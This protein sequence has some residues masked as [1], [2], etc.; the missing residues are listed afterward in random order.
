MTVA[1]LSGRVSG[2]ST[3][4]WVSFLARRPV[5][6]WSGGVRDG[7]DVL[8]GGGDLLC[9]GPGRGDFEASAAPAADEAGGG[10]QD[11]IA[12][13]LRLC[14]CEVAVQG[15][16]LQPGQQDAGDHGGVEPG[17]VQ[18][19]V[20]GGS[21]TEPGVLAGADRPRRGRGRGG[22]H[23]CRPTGPASLSSWLA[24]W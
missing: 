3:R 20:T 14:S 15:Q 18:P 2:G 11:A 21:P 8:P 16:E 22:R 17:L 1:R 12:Q 7:L 4:P 10:V 9:P 6:C 13:R 23:R 19:V 24:G 5:S